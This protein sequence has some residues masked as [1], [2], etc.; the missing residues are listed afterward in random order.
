MCSPEGVEDTPFTS[1]EM[2]TNN[3]CSK[4]IELNIGRNRNTS[5]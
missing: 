1:R 4:L 5:F 3:V 2:A